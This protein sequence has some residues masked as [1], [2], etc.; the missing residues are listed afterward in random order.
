MQTPTD[1][2]LLMPQLPEQHPVHV[3]GGAWKVAPAGRQHT[4]PLHTCA[5]AQVPQVPPQPLLPQ[6]LPL[7]DGVQQL[8]DR[9]T[10]PP[11][12]VPQVPPQPL[13]PQVLPEQLGAH[14]HW[15]PALQVCP[16]AQVPQVPPQ[17]SLPQ[18]LPP[19]FFTQQLLP[20]H[21]SPGP[22]VPHTPPQPSAPQVLPEQVC[23]QHVDEKGS[24]TM[25]PGQVPQVPPQPSDPHA[26]PAQLGVQHALIAHWVPTAHDFCCER[27]VPSWGYAHA[28][29]VAFMAMK[30]PMNAPPPPVD[31]GPKEAKAAPPAAG[32]LVTEKKSPPS[33][34]E[35]AY[36]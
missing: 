3:Y 2:W 29:V 34:F 8:F 26:L 12:Q 15:P 23:V 28:T 6:V 1:V 24:H 22:H 27:T 19:Q 25:L 36:T 13:L 31:G 4:E 32:A 21:A 20:T 9:H 7:Q 11:P 10:A 33:S 30:L 35:R 18:S 5:P 16:L 14:T 17:S